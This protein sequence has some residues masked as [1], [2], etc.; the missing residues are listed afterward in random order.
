M[1]KKIEKKALVHD[2]L[3]SIDP[4]PRLFLAET[5]NGLSTTTR[6]NSLPISVLSNIPNQ[7]WNGRGSGGGLWNIRTKH[8]LPPLPLI[9]YPFLP[10]K[11]TP[12][13]NKT[14]G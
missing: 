3:H 13:K 7:Q 4:Q 9:P 6:G 12:Q 1:K 14:G 10:Q 11:K 5:P 2:V 8:P